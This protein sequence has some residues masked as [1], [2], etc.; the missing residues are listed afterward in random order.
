MRRMASIIC[1]RPEEEQEYRQL[2]PAVWLEVLDK[3]RRSNI[4]NDSIF[5]ATASCSGTWS[6]SV[7]TSRRTWRP[8]RQTRGRGSG[9]HSPT[10]AR[11]A[12]PRRQRVPDEQAAVI[13]G[14]ATTWYGLS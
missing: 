7:R 4:R 3:I 12:C 9:E 11:S 6:T 5:C 8:G 1:I 10:R 14:T 13:G 2:N